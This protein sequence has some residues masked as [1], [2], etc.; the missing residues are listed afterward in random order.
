MSFIRLATRAAFS[1]RYHWAAPRLRNHLIPRAGFSAAA[2]L[3]R[4]IIQSRVLEVFKGFE[5][6]DPAKVIHETGFYSGKSN[7][8]FKLS[9]TSSFTNDLGLDSLDAVELVMAVEEVRSS[10]SAIVIC[11]NH[12]FSRSSR[13]K[14]RTLRLMKFRRFNKVCVLSRCPLQ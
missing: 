6:V 14:S 8:I 1:P 10:L 12:V 7:F 3:S 13:L 11:A 9:L 5:K 4:D 2:G